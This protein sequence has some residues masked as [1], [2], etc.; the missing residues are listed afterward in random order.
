MGITDNDQQQVELL[1]QELESCTRKRWKV[2]DQKTATTAKFN[3][4]LKLIY[5]RE[6]RALN[7]IDHLTDPDRFP[8]F[9]QKDKE[10]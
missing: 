2:A 7:Q 10:D 9:K 3:E 4:E 1:R 5:E 6:K 8:L